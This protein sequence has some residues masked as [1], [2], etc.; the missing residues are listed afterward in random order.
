MRK[1]TYIIALS[2]LLSIGCNDS[3]TN[4]GG[5]TNA[6]TPSPADLDNT[7]AGLVA[8]QSCGELETY[9]KELA[10]S[11]LDL[12]VQVAQTPGG[13]DDIG[14]IAEA[15]D[16][17]G[18]PTASGSGESSGAGSTGSTT[19]DFSGTNNQVA[20]VDEADL[21]KTN[22]NFIFTVAG[23][24]LRILRALP[25]AE[26]EEV[27]T[28]EIPGSARE[29][30]LSGDRLLVYSRSYGSTQS[31]SIG[32]V[33]S[34]GG[35]FAQP[36][37]TE[38]ETSIDTADDPAEDG[39]EGSAGGA[40][41]PAQKPSAEQLDQLRGVVTFLTVL[42]VSTPNA[43]AVER[44]ITIEG[45]YTSARLIDGKAFTVLRSRLFVPSIWEIGSSTNDIADTGV[46]EDIAVSEEASSTDEFEGNA[47]IPSEG[48]EPT[49]PTE[50]SGKADDVEDQIAQMKAEFAAALDEGSLDEWM[51]KMLD[52]IDG[53][54]TEANLSDCA[55]FY[56]PTIQQGLSLVAVIELDL[57]AANA[58]LG[59][60]VIIGEADTVYANAESLYVASYTYGYWFW[61]GIAALDGSPEGG[62]FSVIHKFNLASDSVSYAASGKVSGRILNQFSLDEH[63]GNLRVATT[64]GFGDASDNG[65]YVLDEAN[66]KLGIIGSTENLA[67]GE[68]IYSARFIG[69]KGYIVTFRQIDPLFTLDL[70]EPT[71]PAVVGELK[72]PGFSTYIHPLS[73]DY[74]LTIGR[75][76]LDQGEWVEIQGI[77]LQIFDVSDP[78][79]PT[80]AFKETFGSA[81]SIST[82]LYDHRAFAW[83][84]EQGI[85]AVPYSQYSGGGD[86]GFIDMPITDEAVDEGDDSASDEGS[87]ATIPPPPEEEEETP[88]QWTEPSYE[89][90]V[91]VFS[92]STEDGFA[93]LGNIDST[94]LAPESSW[95]ATI[96][97][98]IRI[99][100][101][102]YSIGDIGM[103]VSALS[104]LS[105]VA[106][107]VFEIFDDGDKD[108]IID[109]VEP[110]TPVPE[111]NPEPD[112]GEQPTPAEG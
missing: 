47:S 80:V 68:D 74:L 63:E 59:S 90:G 77:Q 106:Q 50:D 67:K 104:D 4:L 30:F 103:V 15:N 49:E 97:R 94:T 27:S 65:V 89:A 34:A 105:E 18:A 41:S 92:V 42:N 36:E 62:D 81:G 75:D 108:I 64:S 45:D 73:D 24:R 111:G 31:P 95:R 9:I 78:A 44:T 7:S 54:T 69:D 88:S 112:M 6:P 3:R 37:P 43:P 55:S 110:T 20:G 22:G 13:I 85:L 51:P 29:L 32:A 21:V 5:T 16:T 71:A 72:I 56:K 84:P 70:S 35:T 39:S 102:L 61:N 83:F 48:M 40:P 26:A 19:P 28:L 23:N 87:D 100:D 60:T 76:A 1:L 66:G 57:S 12:M 91:K 2:T 17:A 10:L 96:N 93:E 46:P 58:D 52:S 101:H 79:T 38:P 86:G 82:A 109:V 107:V 98:I 99:E 14:V 33:G 8:V 53:Q 11:E 25:A